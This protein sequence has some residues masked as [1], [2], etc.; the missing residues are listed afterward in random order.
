[1]RLYLFSECR[2][3][4]T[5]QPYKHCCDSD[6]M[7]PTDAGLGE[8]QDLRQVWDEIVLLDQ[9]TGVGVSWDSVMVGAGIIS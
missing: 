7:D 8:E 4:D 9:D 5:D 1:M 6:N 3:G 2:R